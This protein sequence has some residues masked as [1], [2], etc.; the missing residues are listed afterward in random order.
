VGEFGEAVA[1]AGGEDFPVLPVGDGA[2]DRGADAGDAVVADLGVGVVV[3]SGWSPL[4]RI[5]GV[6]W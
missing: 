4:G 3:A 6:P 2:F 5:T 1:V